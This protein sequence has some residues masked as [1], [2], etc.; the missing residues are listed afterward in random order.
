MTIDEDDCSYYNCDKPIC[1]AMKKLAKPQHRYCEE[2]HK[3]FSD[4]LNDINDGKSKS[5]ALLS[6]WIKANGGAKVFAKKCAE[7]IA[8]KIAKVV[9]IFKSVNN[10]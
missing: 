7:D 6:F 10:K 5:K 1:S 4:I 2:H 9:K 8:P 3:A